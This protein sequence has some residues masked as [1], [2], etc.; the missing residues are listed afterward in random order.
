MS[1]TLTSTGITFPDSTTQT[2]S[3]STPHVVCKAYITTNPTITT[4]L[5]A[6]T[7]IPINAAT[8]DNSSSFDTTN[9]WF[10]VPQ[11]GYY[12]VSYLVG[13][14]GTNSSNPFSGLVGTALSFNGTP[15]YAENYSNLYYS[16]VA[17]RVKG[18]GVFHFNSG[19]KISCAVIG[20]SVVYS[21]P[22]CCVTNYEVI[23]ASATLDIHQVR[24]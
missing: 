1:T 4:S 21:G 12:Y 2:S 8:Y 15:A 11:A 9:H 10:V 24:F 14:N 19:D 23:V 20:G 16:P 18:S 5:S 22:C 17:Y 13:I 3:A 6:W 7:T